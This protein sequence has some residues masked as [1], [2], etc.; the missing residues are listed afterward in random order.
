MRGNKLEASDL[1]DF[2]ILKHYRTIRRWAS[3]RHNISQADLEL[4]IYLDCIDFFN[5]IDFINGTYS[6]S[7]DNRRWARL[8]KDDWITL[9]S[10]RNGTTIKSNIYKVSFKGKRLINQIYKIMV[11]EEDLP[12]STHKKKIKKENLY[13]DKVL[14]KSMLH[15]NKDKTV[16]AK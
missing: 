12:I 1:K 9:F 10:K 7:W 8:K 14:M 2:K 15:S 5:R 6:Y 16:N 3:R 4:L 13:T 11:G